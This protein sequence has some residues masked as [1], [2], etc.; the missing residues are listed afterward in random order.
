MHRF[1]ELTLPTC[2]YTRMHAV[3]ASNRGTIYQSS[4]RKEKSQGNVKSC[5][6]TSQS[7]AGTMVPWNSRMSSLRIVRSLNVAQNNDVRKVIQKLQPFALSERAILNPVGGRYM[8]ELNH[9]G[10]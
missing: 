4:T 3:E 6:V 7:A 8:A 2:L 10:P 9:F 1:T 5:P